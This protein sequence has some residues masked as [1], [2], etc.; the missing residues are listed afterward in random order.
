MSQTRT[1]RGRSATSF[2][3]PRGLR[4]LAPAWRSYC[5]RR[6]WAVLQPHWSPASAD[7]P[8]RCSLSPTSTAATRTSTETPLPWGSVG[9]RWPCL[10]VCMLGHL[11]TTCLYALIF[12]YCKKS[13]WIFNIVLNLKFFWF[14]QLF[15]MP[16]SLPF[17]TNVI[18]HTILQEGCY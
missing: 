15:A 13:F 17:I 16:S 4:R 11:H 7:G 10:R 9:E 12:L 3:F 6:N 8:S 2:S 18:S 14:S 1:L 5:F